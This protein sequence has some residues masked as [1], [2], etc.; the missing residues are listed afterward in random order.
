MY[1]VT[2]GVRV[3]EV[4]EHTF[5]PAGSM[6]LAGWAPMWSKSSGRQG[7]ATAPERFASGKDRPMTA[8]V[9]RDPIPP[10]QSR[11]IAAR[12]RNRLAI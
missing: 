2:E 3:V 8:P 4:A 12:R 6:I 5:G 1:D 9:F 11:Y 10:A 7:W